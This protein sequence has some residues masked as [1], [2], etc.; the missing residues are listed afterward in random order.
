MSCSKYPCYELTL[1]SAEVLSQQKAGSCLIARAVHLCYNYLTEKHKISK[2]RTV[3]TRRTP[4][5]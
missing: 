2:T 4:W 1:A 5:K 3:Y